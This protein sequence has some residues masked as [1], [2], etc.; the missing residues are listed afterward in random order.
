MAKQL[1]RN[2]RGRLTR[3]QLVWVDGGFEIRI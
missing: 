1:F 3:L 2:A